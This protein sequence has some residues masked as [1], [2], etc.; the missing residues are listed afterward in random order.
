GLAAS[1]GLGSL[2]AVALSINTFAGELKNHTAFPLLAR[3]I[4]RWAFILGK[5]LGVVVA[6]IG[7]ITIMDLATAAT[8]ALYGATIPSAFWAC[9]WLG[10]VEIAVVVAVSFAFS[11]LAVPTLAAAYSAG[12]ILAGNLATD[13]QN[14][15]A[16]LQRKG[17][18]GGALLDAAY[19]VLPDLQ[20]LSARIQ[21]ANALPLPFE[22]LVAGT[23]YGVSYAAVAML[24]AMWVFSRRRAI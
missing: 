22:T 9:M 21:A 17:E 7:V 4:P 1:S 10:W 6:M 19:Y 16:R 8:V 12:V 14:Y 3:P 15:A 20:D 13:V 5:Y 23:L 24:I 2:I 18:S 11:S